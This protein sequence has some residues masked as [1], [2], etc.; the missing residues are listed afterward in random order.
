MNDEIRKVT[1]EA[2]KF[3]Y[4][5]SQYF[6]SI[7]F[8]AE[9]IANQL[10][11]DGYTPSFLSYGLKFAAY[12]RGDTRLVYDRL[13]NHWYGKFSVGNNPEDDEHATYGFGI[14]YGFNDPASNVDPWIPLIYLFKGKVKEIGEWKDWEYSRNLFTPSN[15]LNQPKKEDSHILELD[16]K[17]YDAIEYVKALIFPLGAVTNTDDVSKI[18]KPSVEALRINDDTVLKNISGYLLPAMEE[19]KFEGD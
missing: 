4:E 17:N 8:L 12:D 5:A 16:V 3:W 6:E 7:S 11:K 15:L 10:A 18:V 19:W 14:T 2:A 1:H 13:K 9:A